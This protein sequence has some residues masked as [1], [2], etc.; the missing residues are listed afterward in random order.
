MGFL[1][2]NIEIGA[3]TNML[4]QLQANKVASEQAQ[5]VQ[6]EAHERVRKLGGQT[7]RLRNRNTISVPPSRSR[8]PSSSVG[9]ARLDAA[10][11]GWSVAST[12]K[13]FVGETAE[14]THFAERTV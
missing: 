10:T 7:H 5:T 2:V 9:A 1:T 3:V 6:A 4:Y 12:L 13:C 11:I 14:A 8:F